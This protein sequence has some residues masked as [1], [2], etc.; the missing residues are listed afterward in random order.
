MMEPLPGFRQFYPEACSARNALF[1][2]WRKGARAFAF[3]EYDAPTLE[4]LA[5]YVEKSGQEVVEQLFQFE[6]KGGRVVALRPELTPSLASMVGAK[7]ASL[8]RPIKWFNIGECYRYERP[9]KGRLRAFYQFNA[10]I[11]GE[12]GPAAD[13]ELIALLITTFMGFG[14]TQ[15]H[16]HVRLSDRT[17]WVAA[18]R[19]W[20][21]GQA[22]IPSVLS[23]IDKRERE[24]AS[25]LQAKLDALGLEGAQLLGWIDTLASV[26]SLDA[27]R[28]FFKPFA[29]PELEAR[30]E[31]WAL[32]WAQLDAM[33]LLPFI[34]L[35]MG[36]VR[37][38]AYYTGFVFEAFERTGQGRALAGG[39]R[40]DDLV[41]KLGGPSLPATGFA[42][43]DVTLHDCLAANGCLPAASPL[44]DFFFAVADD[45]L[46]PQA[47]ALQQQLRCHGLRV[48][49]TLKPTTLPKQLKFAHDA[50]IPYTIVLDA[51]GAQNNTVSVKSLKDGSTQKVAQTQLLPWALGV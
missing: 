36:I 15:E 28:V 17:L 30:L 19:A 23:I 44:A 46:R 32:L 18:L 1:A 12:A 8:K 51:E 45:I 41:E 27:M 5:L 6:D 10:D 22:S 42:M 43:G 38:L 13:A 4:P 39:G 2:G 9:Q 26:R 47:L 16:V 25:R 14:L 21:V 37:G 48:Q 3:E 7:A 35:D 29:A 31:D 40:Y 20:G 11:F 33:G 50:K 24:P 49:A 34:T